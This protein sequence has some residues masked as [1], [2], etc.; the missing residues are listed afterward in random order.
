V[1]TLA[2]SLDH[3]GPMA[4]TVEDCAILLQALAGHDPNDPASANV[5]IPDYRADLEA[6]IEGLRIGAPLAYLETVADLS[7]ETYAAYRTA[8]GELERLGAKVEAVEYPES[9]H[10]GPL[11]AIILVA[12]AYAYH[13][14]CFRESPDKYGQPFFSRTLPG[15]L[16]SAADYITAQRGRA[17]I[18]RAF[19]ELMARV[20]LLALPTFPYPA[21]TFA[22]DLS[23]PAW[24]RTS[25]TRTF[26]LTGQPAISVPCGFSSAGLPIGL[27]LAGRVFEDATVLRAARAY[28]RATD[29]H[30]RRP[31]LDEV[32]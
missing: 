12:E 23:L 9:Q 27:Q 16:L 21:V 15:A 25:M 14:S 7:A 20:D 19:A 32:A 8:L 2:W 11:G 30:Q 18:K 6:G 26:N 10:I 1:L 28:E 17:R 4:R 5:P 13:Q 29:W 22:E 24:A 3:A 31:P